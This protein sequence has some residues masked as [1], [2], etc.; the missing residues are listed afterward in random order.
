MDTP[1]AT[2]LF[3][4]YHKIFTNTSGNSYKVWH[5]DLNIP[6]KYTSMI[7]R[8]KF[9]HGCY[10]A[11]LA[12]L[13]IIPSSLCEY[14][15]TE[16]TLDHLLFSCQKYIKECNILY[17]NLIR[18]GVT[19]PFNLLHVLCLNKIETLTYIITFLSKTGVKI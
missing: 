6:R 10:P 12:R 11:H 3:Y 7:S 17:T 16:G 5:D 8:L 9:G 1:L 15:N 14:C 19:A 13:N 2:V 18:C 4:I